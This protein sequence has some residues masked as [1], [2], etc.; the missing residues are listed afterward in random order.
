[1]ELEE[2][3]EAAKERTQEAISL[4]AEKRPASPSTT[5]PLSLLVCFIHIFVCI[6]AT[7]LGFANSAGQPPAISFVWPK[8]HEDD[9][10]VSVEAYKTRTVAVLGINTIRQRLCERDWINEHYQ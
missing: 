4:D 10:I 1:M 6:L 2:H 3:E 5:F 9:Q 8:S 7:V